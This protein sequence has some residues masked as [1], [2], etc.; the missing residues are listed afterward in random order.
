M[1]YKKQVLLKNG[2]AC[3]LRSV[4]GK[5]AAQVLNNIKVTISETDNL[6]RLPT[7]PL[8]TLEKEA[9]YLQKTAD[10]PKEIKVAAFIDGKIV[11]LAGLDPVSTS[12]KCRH[13]AGFGISVQKQYWGLGLGNLLMEIILNQAV[14]AGYEQ[15][16]LDV[17]TTNLTALHLY[18]KFGFEIFGTHEKAF[19]LP[20]GEYQSLYLMNK[21]L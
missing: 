7:E 4:D 21:E 9:E 18:K 14:I 19:L 15:V 12:Q 1:K 16:E 17:V 13:R 3:L 6:M 8:Y 10:S 5:D 20:S 11:A 2:T